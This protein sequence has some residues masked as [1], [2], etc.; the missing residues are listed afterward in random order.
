MDEKLKLYTITEK[1]VSSLREFESFSSQSIEKIVELVEKNKELNETKPQKNTMLNYL[2]MREN[3]Y[4]LELE[5]RKILEKLRKQII[6][7]GDHYFFYLEAFAEFKYEIMHYSLSKI[8]IRTINEIF[9]KIDKENKKI[10]DLIVIFEN[11]N[12]NELLHRKSVFRQS[13]SKILEY[14]YVIENLVYEDIYYIKELDFSKLKLLKTKDVKEGDVIILKKYYKNLT[15]YRKL[16]VNI[17]GSTFIHSAIV[18]KISKDKIYLFE[19]NAYNDKLTNIAILEKKPNYKYVVLRP[20]RE[21]SKQGI[22]Q[23]KEIMEANV[24]IKFSI[25]KTLSASYERLKE[26]HLRNSFLPLKRK[27]NPFKNLKGTFCSE[28]VAKIYEEMGI[29]LG[30]SDDNSIIS[31]LDILNSPELEIIGYL[32]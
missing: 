20:K 22:K 13:Y 12:Y 30:L 25:L 31:P 8:D 6:R 18:Y 27:K 7:I 10:Q 14:L 2:M 9:K 19:A 21:F 15:I 3:N 26:L 29:R 24:G 4:D 1:L 5:K 17:L 11:T 32:Q 16:I 28:A 23:I